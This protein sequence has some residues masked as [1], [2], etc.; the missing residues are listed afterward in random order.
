MG[1][2]WC[3]KVSNNSNALAELD[4]VNQLL[5]EACQLLYEVGQQIVVDSH[6]GVWQAGAQE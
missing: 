5:Y 3:V 2:L 1:E 4:E 6:Y